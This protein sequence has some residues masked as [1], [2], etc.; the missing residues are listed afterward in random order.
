MSALSTLSAFNYGHTITTANRSIDFD[1]GN[2]TQT[3]LIRVGSYTLGEFVNQVAIA[4]NTAAQ[5]VTFS[6]SLDRATRTITISGDGN[7]DLLIS[8]GPSAAVSAYS[9]IGFTGVD[10][11][12]LST[13]EGDSPSG[14]QY[15]PQFR[16]Q[17]YTPFINR[18]E[19]AESAVA[20]SASGVVQVASFGRVNFMDC[21]IKYI[22]N[23]PQRIKPPAPIENN[24]NA[25]SEARAFLQ[26]IIGKR[27]IEFL[28]DRDSETNFTNCFLESSRASR[29]GTG[30]RLEELTRENLAFHFETGTL[31]FRQ[32]V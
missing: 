2:G 23:R 24:P 17:N 30:F 13:Y 8:T 12:G 22:T 19:T 11:T 3:A 14:L 10:L 29:D 15:R 27:P 6:A 5:N 32:I 31:T 21:N 4:L 16:L 7:F 9:L 25:V 18:E 20:T 1:D 28:P 26:Y